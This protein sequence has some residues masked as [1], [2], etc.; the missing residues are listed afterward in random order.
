MA[1]ARSTIVQETVVPFPTVAAMDAAGQAIFNIVQ[2]AATKAEQ[3]LQQARGAAQML[4]LQLLVAEER[5]VA[6]EAEIAQLREKLTQAEQWMQRIG[7][8]VEERFLT[9]DEAPTPQQPARPLDPQEYASKR[10]FNR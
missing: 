2:Q 3:D 4:S 6:L 1:H 7:A 5:I 10:M 8:L 9:P